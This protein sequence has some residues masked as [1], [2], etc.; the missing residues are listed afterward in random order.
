[1]S[2]NDTD[3]GR[4]RQ[5]G[6]Q[7]SDFLP[8]AQ[9]ISEARHS[10]LASLLVLIICGF[11]IVILAWAA[12]AEVDQAV[13]AQGQVR[14]GGRVKLVNHPEG[15]SVAEI[16]VRDGDLVRQGDP[17]L[18][19]D[20]E[21]INGEV[22][23]LRGDLQTLEAELARLEAEAGDDAV[24][25][26]PDIVARERP[27]LVATHTRLLEARR[28]SLESRRESAEREIEQ[29]QSDINSFRVRINTLSQSRDVLAEQVRSLRT[30]TDKGH[31]PFL[32][33]QSVQRQLAETEGQL[34]E[35][36]QSLDSALSALSASKSRRREIDD[37]SRSDVL[38]QLA[39]TRGARDRTARNL[40]QATARLDRTIVR[41]PVDGY[42]QNLVVNNTGQAVRPNEPL[43]SVV[44]Q[45][46]NLVIEARVAN[47]D[48][49][50]VETGQQ[51]N[52]K[53][54]AYDF[55]K[56]GALNGT[57]ERVARDANTDEQSGAIF[58]VV[59]IRTDRNYLGDVP[60]RNQV[61]PG[62]QVDAELK[63][64]SRSVLSYLTDRVIGTADEAFRE[65]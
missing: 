36:R 54:R 17:L 13:V 12:I 3:G 45:S 39:E 55:I 37:E 48:I 19:L 59:E 16:M 52:I 6:A 21:I 57:V 42:V 64:G 15:G 60:G 58:Y 25:R 28:D 23:R 62:M 10:P 43:M 2:R 34:Q 18:R 30:L 29:A 65:R 63:A 49:S 31:F 51:A 41:S 24:I 50:S 8:E 38:T 56:Y 35:T 44:P 9:A 4:T 47:S 46:D 26:F 7:Y 1:M 20:S 32:R 14:P 11:F 5:R 33:F 61:R 22:R 27:D 40:E 53:V